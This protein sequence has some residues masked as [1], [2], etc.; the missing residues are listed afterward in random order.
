MDKAR[1]EVGPAV[2][3]R[4]IRHVPEW[5]DPVRMVEMGVQSKD[6]AEAGLHITKETLWKAGVLTNPV[7][8]SESRQRSIQSGRRHSDRGVGIRSI[9]APRSIGT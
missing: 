7:T 5:V 1:V 3:I 2:G 8:T 9:E 6:L 4:T